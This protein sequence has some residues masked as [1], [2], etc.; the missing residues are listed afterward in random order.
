MPPGDAFV[1]EVYHSICRENSPID[2]TEESSVRLAK[3]CGAMLITLG[4]NSDAVEV[5][6]RVRGAWLQLEQDGT[7]LPLS[8]DE[9]F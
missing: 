5:G 1:D 6:R 8:R 2:L 7:K 9:V 3:V 4:R